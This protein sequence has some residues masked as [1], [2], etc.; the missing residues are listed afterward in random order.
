MEQSDKPEKPAFVANMDPAKIYPTPT[1]DS[2]MALKPDAKP[3]RSKLKTVSLVLLGTIGFLFILS[4]IG[5]VIL[6]HATNSWTGKGNDDLW[7]NTKNWSLGRPI[8][9]QTL[10]FNIKDINAKHST[11]VPQP[12]NTNYTVYLWDNIRNL[13][14]KNIVFNSPVAANAATSNASPYIG[15]DNLHVSGQ[16]INNIRNNSIAI[17]YNDITFGKNVSIKI[18]SKNT[19]LL[20]FQGKTYL[21]QGSTVHLQTNQAAPSSEIIFQ[22]LSGK[23]NIYLD[24]NSNANFPTSSPNLSGNTTIASG[25][26]LHLGEAATSSSSTTAPSSIDG[27]GNSTITIL[28]SGNLELDATGWGDYGG[29]GTNQFVVPNNIVMD[30]NGTT[31]TA[32]SSAFSYPASHDYNVYNATGTITGAINSCIAPG[33][34]GCMGYLQGQQLNTITFTG[35]VKLT[36]N[37]Q[38]G[39]I[40]YR[41]YDST[42]P[43]AQDYFS[44]SAYI[45]KK[46]II[47]IDKYNLTPVIHSLVQIT[48]S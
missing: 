46:P 9:G 6:S 18:Q 4:I 12:Y 3:K 30:G 15:G 43:A 19:L 5:Y 20:S 35:Q 8:N 39:V 42:D 2:T 28:N 47:N 32:R 11:V 29:A 41:D 48:N 26:V 7:S 24:P 14:V 25:A 40:S 34:M 33:Q 16:I 17:I 38:I 1:S 36:G 22:S 27:L 45:F 37:T 21:S 23:S 10:V 44:Y 31:Y 13:S